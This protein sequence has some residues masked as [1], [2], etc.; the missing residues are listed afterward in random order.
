MES[1]GQWEV[2][3]AAIGALEFVVVTLPP[4]ALQSNLQ[5]KS[6]NNLN[7]ALKEELK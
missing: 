6:I 4:G 1:A 5:P 3:V 7:S 2:E